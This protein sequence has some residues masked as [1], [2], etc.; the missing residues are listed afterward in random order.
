ML[1]TGSTYDYF[2]NDAWR[3]HS[4]TL[5]TLKDAVNLR[6]K[7]YSSIEKA[8]ITKDPEEKKR[9]LTF[10]VAGGGPTGVEMAGVIAEVTRKLTKEEL[11]LEPS[12]INIYLVEAMDRILGMYREDQSQYA[13]EELEKLNEETQEV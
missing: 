11:K 8:L 12:D 2:G 10:V 13:K 7:I 5:K 3:K 1:A 4:Y 6:N 9:L